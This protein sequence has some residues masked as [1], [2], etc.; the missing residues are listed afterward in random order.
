M[1]LSERAVKFRIKL[2]NDVLPHH[3]EAQKDAMRIE[4]EILALLKEVRAEA[5]DDAIRRVKGIADFE[6]GRLIE[7]TRE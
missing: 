1:R 5:L 2:L 3:P 6:I 4:E 7:E